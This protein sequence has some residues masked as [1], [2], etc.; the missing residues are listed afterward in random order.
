MW[1]KLIAAF[2]GAP[3]EQIAEYFKEK[4]RLKQE[5]SKAKLEGKIE[6]ERAK[7]AAQAAKQAH[8]SNWEMASLANSGW[9]D[10]F[11]LLTISY[12][13]YASFIP[14]LQD[15]VA[16]GFSILG[17]TPMWY[18]A[19]VLAVYLAIYGIRWKGAESIKLPGL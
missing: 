14:Y 18:M 5:L 3:V 8:I 1:S 13:V 16:E 17:T 9:K 12:P 6:V 7:A 15:S 11:V 19:M 4:Q 2:L 10:E